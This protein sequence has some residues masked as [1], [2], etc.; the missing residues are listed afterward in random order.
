[1]G[2]FIYYVSRERGRGSKPKDDDCSRRG[3][4]S[5]FFQFMEFKGVKY[6]EKEDNFCTIYVKAKQ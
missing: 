5:E 3:V 2:L 6:V 1:M 4:G